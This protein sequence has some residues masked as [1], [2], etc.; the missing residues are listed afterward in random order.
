MR[1][2]LILAFRPA[3]GPET[4]SILLTVSAFYGI[5]YGRARV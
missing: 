2:G 5:I 3:E 4:P 1:R